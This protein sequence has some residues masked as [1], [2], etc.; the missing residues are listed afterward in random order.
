MS[1]STRS[2]IGESGRSS[3]RTLAIPSFEARWSADRRTVRNVEAVGEV[4]AW[5]ILKQQSDEL[6]ERL[7]MLRDSSVPSEQIAGPPIECY[8]PSLRGVRLNQGLRCTK[9]EPAIIHSFPPAR[10]RLV[11]CA[12]G[13]L[14][15]KF[16]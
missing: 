16:R 2:K 13:E 11:E 15:S 9:C 14:L 1:G 7:E 8:L 12:Q 10:F 5:R 6:V 4:C 3:G